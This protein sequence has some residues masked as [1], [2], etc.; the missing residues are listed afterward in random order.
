M[1]STTL[2]ADWAVRR[3][4]GPLSAREQAEFEAWLTRMYGIWAPMAVPEAV[5]ARL[6]R[7]TG[8]GSDADEGAV[9]AVWSRRRTL[10]AAG[11]ATAAAAGI[12]IAL[13]PRGVEQEK[14]STQIGQMRE[15]VLVDGSVVSLNTDIGK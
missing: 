8:V 11:A 12:G 4:L 9:P 10:L 6:E 2:A 7:L 13:F 3:D 5:L 15:I 14:F 1:K